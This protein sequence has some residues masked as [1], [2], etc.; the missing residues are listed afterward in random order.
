MPMMEL[1][2]VQIKEASRPV[3][4]SFQTVRNQFVH[5]WSIV[6]K[7]KQKVYKCKTKCFDGIKFDSSVKQSI[8]VTF[9]VHVVS[10]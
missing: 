4:H 3:S 8:I 6:Q 5:W 1:E 2:Q 7:K 10:I 9:G